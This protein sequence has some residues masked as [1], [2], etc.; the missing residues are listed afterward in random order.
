MEGMI[1]QSMVISQD[2]YRAQQEKG[3]ETGRWAAGLVTKL[4]EVTH[5]QWLYRNLV[6]HEAKTGLLRTEQKEM[7][8]QEIDK[9]LELGNNGLLEEDQYLTEINIG[10][11]EQDITE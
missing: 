7:I 4:L 8:Q 11:M 3:W 9:Q 1:S 6:I 10:D 5:G 2:I